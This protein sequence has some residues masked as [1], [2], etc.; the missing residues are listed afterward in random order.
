MWG[1]Q[2]RIF[3]QIH[4][5]LLVCLAI[6]ETFDSSVSS[7]SQY[8]IVSS[9]RD[10]QVSLQ[11]PFFPPSH[12]SFSWTTSKMPITS[13]NCFLIV[14]TPHCTFLNLTIPV[15]M[16]PNLPASSKIYQKH[17]KVNMSVTEMASN[18]FPF[19]PH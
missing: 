8:F 13:I 15:C 2:E 12:Y 1:H 9:A 6:S 14:K 5:A 7:F 19:F 11:G 18:C 16:C 3:C 10:S 4:L 17:I